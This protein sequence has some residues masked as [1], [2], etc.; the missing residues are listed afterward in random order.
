MLENAQKTGD[1]ETINR[2]LGQPNTP[3][4]TALTK[5]LRAKALTLQRLAQ[6]QL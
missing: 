5:E 2:V 6:G 3:A 1:T 4:R